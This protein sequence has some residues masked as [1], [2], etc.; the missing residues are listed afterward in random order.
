MGS[1]SAG[2]TPSWPGIAA[3]R[4]KHATP[5]L[6][7]AGCLDSGLA[8]AGIR[9]LLSIRQLLRPSG[10]SHVTDIRYFAVITDNLVIPAFSIEAMA[11][12][13]SP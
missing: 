7:S 12:A 2:M 13:T 10:R 1:M 11:R 6:T 4:E 5:R 9:G 8:W 3:G